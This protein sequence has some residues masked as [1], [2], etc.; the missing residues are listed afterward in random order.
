M[1]V[2]YFSKGINDVCIQSWVDIFWVEFGWFVF[3]LSLVCVVI[4]LLIFLGC[5]LKVL[6]CYYKNF[7]KKV[8]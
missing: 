1:V 5:V 2:I 4:Y 6:I 7:L 8:K 3:I